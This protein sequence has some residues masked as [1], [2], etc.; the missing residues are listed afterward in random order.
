MRPFI[1]DDSLHCQSLHSLYCQS[2][3]QAIADQTCAEKK[4]VV[5]TLDD[6]LK[7]NASVVS[8]VKKHEA[9]KPFAKTSVM[10]IH[11]LTRE[12]VG[13]IQALR[14]LGCHHLT[15]QFLGY[16]PD[17]AKIFRPTLLPV[18]DA[19]L[20]LVKLRTNENDK[21]SIDRGF[22]K[23]ADFLPSNDIDGAIKDKDYLPC[24]RSLSV[25]VALKM[26][27]KCATLK[28]QKLVIVEDGG[29][30]AP[31]LNDAALR[32]LTISDFRK[33]NFVAKD[34]ET[35]KILEKFSDMGKLVDE[36][37]TGTVE[38]TRN[39]YDK[40]QKVFLKHGGKLAKPH[41]TIALSRSK[42]QDESNYVASTCINSLNN[43]LGSYGRTL[44]PRRVCVLGSRGNI[45]GRAVKSFSHRL[46]TGVDQVYGVDLRVGF[47][48]SEERPDWEPSP[49][50]QPLEGV[51]ESRKFSDLPETDR[52]KIDV[53][54]GITGGRQLR[55]DKSFDETLVADDIKFWLESGDTKYNELWLVSGSTKTREFEVVQ[56]F[57]EDL[58][59]GKE[60]YK[61]WQVTSKSWADPLSG[62]DYGEIFS[63][64]PGKGRAKTLFAVN[65]WKPA[66]FMF[67]GVPTEGI[68]GILAQLVDVTVSLINKAS[69]ASGEIHAV[70]YAAIATDGI[71]DA[72]SDPLLKDIPVPNPPG[73]A[74][75]EAHMTDLWTQGEIIL[76]RKREEKKRKREE[77]V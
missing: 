60:R 40:V 11:H 72:A 46:E 14:L 59:N 49:Y 64:T 20:Q 32:N 52:E 23:P 73:T 30:I 76:P 61:D 16:N 42:T 63:F 37:L 8:V 70:D 47:S 12:V 24:Q 45:G 53:I 62:R 57:V 3:Q 66:N 6:Y 38:H 13:T 65:D 17:A 33:E 22:T 34:S 69:S 41:F 58:V 1:I 77:N 74:A 67:Y 68:D 35:D 71:I 28:E 56:Q 19:E 29:Y 54:F 44:R 75:A 10:L 18:P 27:A 2:L 9:T 31:L 21:L 7:Q 50:N 55:D 25:F 51:M 15:A 26:L 36:L 43:A 48:N 4:K 39:G 5:E